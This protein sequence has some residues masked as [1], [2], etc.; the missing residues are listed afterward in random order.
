MKFQNLSHIPGILGA[1]DGA[2]IPIKAPKIDSEVYIN[3][4]CFYGITLQA[5]CDPSLKFID[6]FA[7]YP[8]SVSNVII[9]SNSDIYALITTNPQT[10]FPNGEFIVGDKVYPVLPLGLFHCMYI[11]RGNIPEIQRRFNTSLA[12]TRQVIE[13][14][15]ALLKGRFRR[16]KYLDMNRTDLIPATILASCVL[17]NVCL[18]NDTFLEEYIIEGMNNDNEDGVNS[19]N[20]IHRAVPENTGYQKRNELAELLYYRV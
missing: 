12:S 18:H 17:H 7:G 19:M 1:I 14:S 3:R 2:Y 13:R 8:S 4:K 5:I 11:N 9:F 15:F 6:C 16:L 20:P 10:Y